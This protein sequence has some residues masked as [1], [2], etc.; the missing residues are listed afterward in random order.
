MIDLFIMI[1]YRGRN[2]SQVS[3]DK[4]GIDSTN[5]CTLDT[6]SEEEAPRLRNAVVFMGTLSSFKATGTQMIMNVI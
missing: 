3:L 6:P 1:K 5:L 4:C 2:V